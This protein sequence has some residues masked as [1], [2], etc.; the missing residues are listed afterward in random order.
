[1]KSQAVKIF[2]SEVHTVYL[3]CY[4]YIVVLHLYYRITLYILVYHTRVVLTVFVGQAYYGNSASDSAE[5]KKAKGRLLAVIYMI[6][7]KLFFKFPCFC[8]FVANIHCSQHIL[9]YNTTFI[10]RILNN[11]FRFIV[12]TVKTSIRVMG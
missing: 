6:V 3:L 7:I 12:F 1:V 8:I 9:Q 4:N 5:D 2:S 10:F 11:N